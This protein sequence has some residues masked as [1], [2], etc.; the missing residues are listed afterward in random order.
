M[1]IFVLLVIIMTSNIKQQ[2]GQFYT[3]NYEYI[4]QKLYIPENI[5]KNNRAIC[6]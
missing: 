3:T 2:L 5:T 6:W 4:M 1:I